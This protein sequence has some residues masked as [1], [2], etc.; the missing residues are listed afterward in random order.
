MTMKF[1]QLSEEQQTVVRCM[2]EYCIEQ[3]FCMGMDEGRDLDT[4]E[5]HPWVEEL[6]DFALSDDP[7]PR[8]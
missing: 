8:T 2:V 3:G 1:S 6:L 4:G 5:Y 7:E